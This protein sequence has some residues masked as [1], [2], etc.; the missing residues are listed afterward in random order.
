ME[1][2]AQLSQQHRSQT[3]SLQNFNIHKRLVPGHQP[4][5]PPNSICMESTTTEGGRGPTGGDQRHWRL[6]KKTTET[7]TC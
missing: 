1:S 3:P 6:K 5:C 7:E 2:Q 4:T